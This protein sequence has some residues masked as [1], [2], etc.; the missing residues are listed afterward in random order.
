MEL[1]FSPLACSLGTRV[2]LYEAGADATFTYVDTKTHLTSSG[3]DYREINPLGLVPALRTDHGEVLTENAAV[4]QY[5][6]DAF[7]EARLAPRDGIE[8]V[9]LQQWLCF[10]GTELHKALF[11]PLLDEKSPE[12]AKEYAIAKGTAKLDRL[13]QHLHDR[14]YLLDAFSVADA[15]LGAVLNW[16]SVTPVKLAD[17]PAV[18]AYHKRLHARPNFARAFGEERALWAQRK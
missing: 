1:F 16:A 17:W 7:P 12:G 6:A 9:R 3:A 5:V 8:R 15:Y 13:Q 14:E 11:V 10:I 2:A 18:A 4:L